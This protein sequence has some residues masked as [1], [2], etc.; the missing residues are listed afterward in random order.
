MSCRLRLELLLDD[1]I[2]SI[3]KSLPRLLVRVRL[4]LSDG[5]LNVERVNLVRNSQVR[6]VHVNQA[7][8]KAEINVVFVVF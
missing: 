8:I 5:L 2:F 3:G 6:W 1:A 4:I 7:P